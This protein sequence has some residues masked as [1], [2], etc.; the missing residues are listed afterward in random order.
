M[1]VLSYACYGMGVS[2]RGRS[3]REKENKG[4]EKKSRWVN[5]EILGRRKR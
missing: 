3:E 1:S 2:H 5:L 4:K